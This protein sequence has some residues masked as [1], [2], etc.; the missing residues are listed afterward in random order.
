MQYC[1]WTMFSIKQ[2]NVQRTTCEKIVKSTNSVSKK[3]SY[4][5]VECTL[6]CIC[7]VLY[8]VDDF[9]IAKI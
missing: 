3:K 6:Q 2:K 1:I 9:G 5:V 7:N 4:T 8:S